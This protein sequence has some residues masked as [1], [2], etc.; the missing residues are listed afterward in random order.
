MR[1]TR[2]KKFSAGIYHTIL[3]KAKSTFVPGFLILPNEQCNFEYFGASRSCQVLD[4]VELDRGEPKS[5]TWQRGIVGHRRYPTVRLG[6]P[7]KLKYLHSKTGRRV[8]LARVRYGT[9][10]S[11]RRRAAAHFRAYC[12]GQHSP[13]IRIWS[14]APPYYIIKDSRTC[15]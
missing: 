2:F 15:W 3:K 4:L 12:T 7:A 1:K 10:Q 8:D 13:A 14:S 11:E 6:A 5:S 9:M